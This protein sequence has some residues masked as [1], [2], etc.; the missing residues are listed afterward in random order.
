MA[1]EKKQA[2]TGLTTLSRLIAE[3]RIEQALMTLGLTFAECSGL[4]EYDPEAETAFWRYN[5]ETG[6]ESIHVGPKV[7]VLDQGSIEMVLRHEILHRSLYH[8]FGEKYVDRE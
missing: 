7:A 3:R 4:V 6:V 2:P 5:K 8:G 1:D